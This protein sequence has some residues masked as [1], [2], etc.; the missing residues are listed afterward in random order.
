MGVAAEE[1]D[2]IDDGGPILFSGWMRKQGG[3]LRTFSLKNW[4]TRFFVLQVRTDVVCGGQH[5]LL[6]ITHWVGRTAS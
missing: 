1:M 2:S 6:I 5:N 4:K 3:G